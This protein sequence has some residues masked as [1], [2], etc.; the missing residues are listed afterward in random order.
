MT[1]LH[2]STLRAITR[3]AQEAGEPIVRVDAG[4]I[5]VGNVKIVHIVKD[6]GWYIGNLRYRTA[7]DA[8]RAALRRTA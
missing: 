8:L 3:I 4:C 6:G 5:V 2:P 1:P 7:P